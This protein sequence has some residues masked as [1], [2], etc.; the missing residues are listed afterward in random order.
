[1]PIY[2]YKCSDCG[3]EFEELVFSSDECPEC[4]KCQ[5]T[6]T[7]KL[8]SACKFK[9][10]GNDSIGEASPSMPSMPSSGG[11]CSGCSGGNCS[12]CG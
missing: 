12:S 5:S 4:P 11:G 9:A 3:F 8:M 1:M 7:G 10:G 2:E 6:N